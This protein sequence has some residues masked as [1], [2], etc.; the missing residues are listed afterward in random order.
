M[1]KQ[2]KQITPTTP[3]A[4]PTLKA[5]KN[6]LKV[7]LIINTKGSSYYKIAKFISRELKPLTASATSFIKNSEQFVNKLKN[8]QLQEAEKIAS[9]DI[10][11]MYPSLPKQH[12]I[13]EVERRILSDGFQTKYNRETFV[14]LARIP[15]EF[16]SFRIGNKYYEQADG[17]FIGSPASPCFAELFIQLVEEVSVYTMLHAPRIWIRKVGDTFTI[18]NHETNETL[19]ELNQIHPQTKFTAEEEENGQI[20]FLDC[21]VSTTDDN[22]VKTKV[23]KKP[24]HTVQHTNFH[25]NQPLH[26]KLSTVKTLARRTKLGCTESTDLKEELEY[27]EKMMQLNQFPK[28]IVKK[29]I[30]ETLSKS[31]PSKKKNEDY[32]YAIRM[33]MSYEIGISENITRI[34]KKFNVKLVHTKGKSLKNMFV[35]NI[36]NSLEKQKQS[37]VVYRVTCEDCGSQY[38]GETGRSLET[39]MDEH[40]QDAEGEIEKISGLSEHLRQTIHKANFDD[41]EILNKESNFIKRK[42]K[43]A[44]AIK[45][46]N[47]PLLNKKEEK[48]AIS[49]VWENII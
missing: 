4:R 48:K 46:N 39:R 2:L 45:K 25:S 44:I 17:L 27:I 49:N 37:G 32:E 6:P 31:K 26:L 7:R 19:T 16:M 30:H 38:V 9:F 1:K 3:I 20:P 43:E 42:F 36:T 34:G 35:R 18:N 40:R 22:R 23:Y 29:P 10:A 47:A 28:V 12:V 21:L 13:K 33:Y 24:K 41:V 14:T 5:H 8:I 11:D 15:L